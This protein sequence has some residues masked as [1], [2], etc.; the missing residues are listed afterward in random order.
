MPTSY[1]IYQDQQIAL[2]QLD[3]KLFYL[4]DD[5]SPTTICFNHAQRLF[6]M[7]DIYTIKKSYQQLTDCLIDIYQHLDNWNI[8]HKEYIRW[9]SAEK[10]LY[11][12]NVSTILFSVSTVHLD[13][14]IFAH[15]AKQILSLIA[16]FEEYSQ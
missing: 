14:S 6:A 5:I 3:R 4:P 11:P 15:Q 16:N 8:Y 7:L 12:D 2:C 10:S 1:P 13:Q 9:F